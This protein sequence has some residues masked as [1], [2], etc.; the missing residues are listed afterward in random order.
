MP[1][2]PTLA[3][4][5]INNSDQLE[6]ELH[7]AGG[8]AGLHPGQVARRAERGQSGQLRRPGGRGV[9]CPGRCPR[10]PEPDAR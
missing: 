9:P 2:P 10:H 3:A 7:P 5:Q 1:K 4:G 6:V 8:P